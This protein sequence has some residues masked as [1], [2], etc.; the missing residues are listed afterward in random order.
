MSRSRV[1]VC[2]QDG[3]RLDLNRLAR[4]H[5]IK[6]GT[7][8]GARGIAWTNSYWGE[9]VHGI[10]SADMSIQ[11]HRIWS[12]ILRSAPAAMTASHK[13]PVLGYR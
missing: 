8:I 9:A 10:I 3:L 13:A 2:L 6:F 11:G 1:R 12:G 7:N 5:F 4:K